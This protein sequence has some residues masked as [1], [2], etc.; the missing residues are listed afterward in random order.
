[1]VG[2]E[3]SKDPDRGDRI[4]NA[5]LWCFCGVMVAGFIAYVLWLKA[6]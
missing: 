2:S 1:M 3:M 4:A 5:L 6:A